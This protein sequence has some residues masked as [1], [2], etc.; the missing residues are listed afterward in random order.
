MTIKATLSSTTPDRAR[1]DLLAV[2]V[3]KGRKLGPGLNGVAAALRG[4]EAA[5]FDGAPG[6]VLIVPAPDGVAA[7]SVAFVGLGAPRDVTVDSLR[8]A[9]A[10]LARR[11]RAIRSV[12]TTLADAAPSGVDRADAVG[13]LVEGVALGNYQFL[14]YK[15]EPKR[16][17]LATLTLL[18]ASGARAQSAVDAALVIADATAWARDMVNEPAAAKSPADFAIAAERRLR[19]KGVRVQVWQGAELARRKLAGTI[20]V[21]QGSQRPPRFIR[22][23][24]A[25]AGARTTLALVGKGVVFDSGGLSLKPSAG[26]EQMKTDMSGAA[27][28]VAAMSTL[29]ALGVRSR[30]IGY[31]P[32]VENMPSGTAY[33]LGDVITYRNGKSVE[34]MNTDAEGRLILADALCL[35]TEDDVDAIVDVATLTG[36][37]VVALGSKVA[38]LMT[39]NDGFAE[40]VRSA[41]ERVGERF[42]PM[43]LPPDYRRQLDSEIADLKNTGGS[44]GGMLTAGLFL[45]EFVDDTPWA[46]LDI[47]GPARAEADDGYLTRGGTGFS[48]RTL[49]ELAQT[50]RRP[51]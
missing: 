44:P 43:P 30:V 34:V 18:G 36:A 46:H 48:T 15:Q 17:Q 31:T 6:E 1:A 5:G 40:Q 27:A 7:K 21:G 49:I 10:A 2:P 38:G 50:F 22:M 12:A 19:T 51:R 23:E 3:F 4:A 39:N 45:K 32:L 41:G 42:W 26:M 9:G 8:R 24:Y 37:Q 20:T 25:P 35:A 14:R 28:V 11:A 47:A 29:Q 16:S 33:R 13:A